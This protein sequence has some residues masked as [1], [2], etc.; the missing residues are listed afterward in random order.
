MHPFLQKAQ[1]AYLTANE[2][3][4]KVP[5]K[6]TNFANVFSLKLIIELFEHISINN[7]AI[8]LIY[9]EQPLYSPIYTFSLLELEKLK[10]YINNNLANGFIKPFKFFTGAFIFFNK[11]PDWSLR[12][13]IN[14]QNLNNFILKNRYPLLLVRESLDQLN[15]AQCFS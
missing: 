12:L 14:Y 13:C 11:K 6:Y 5:N 7:H 8:E 1:I 2:A 4:I 9:D 3:S 10:V 15:K